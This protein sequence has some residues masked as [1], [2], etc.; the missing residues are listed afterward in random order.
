ENHKVVSREEWL[1]A[2]RELLRREKELTRHRDEIARARR[3]LPWVRVEK[4][5]SFD[6]P[7]GE[8]LLADLFEGKSQLLVYHYMVDPGWEAGCKSCA[9]WADQFDS[10]VVHLRRRD[11]SMVAISRAPLTKL[12]A[13]KARM[14]WSFPWV[15]SGRS[16]FNH[17]YG[18][19]FT[20]EELAA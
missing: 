20:P 5:Y 4:A 12:E 1:A 13:F 15:S 6:A 19:S 17:D 9:F 3:E 18:V 16:D 11:V 10:I 7:R 2:R 14:G 8:V